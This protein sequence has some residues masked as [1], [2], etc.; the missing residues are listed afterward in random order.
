ML[1]DVIVVGSGI[2]GLSAALNAKKEGLKVAV[3][4]KSSLLR[5]NSAVASGGINAA[6]YS[7]E[8][9]SPELHAQDTIKAAEKLAKENTVKK[10]CEEAPNIINELISLG[11][12]FNKTDD[13]KIAQRAFGGGSKKR[14]CYV[15]DR[16]GSAIVMALLQACR[17]EE[18]DFFTNHYLLN[19]IT[20]KNQ[21]C[22]I[23]LLR[24]A[25]SRVT[26]LGCKALVLAGG[27][28]AGIFK[29]FTTNS[30]ESSGDLIAA[31]FRAGIKI[32]NMEFVQFHPTALKGSGSLISEAARGEGAYLVD[33]NNERF[34]SELATRDILT[35]D[36]L[37][38]IQN[39]HK[40]YL[41]FRH[42]PVEMIENRL[43]STYKTALM[44]AG[45]D[46]KKELLEIS[47]AA[48]YTIGGIWIRDDASTTMDGVYACGECAM[49]G[50]H[51]AN[52][53]GG[54]SLLESSYFGRIA[55]KEATTYAKK[56]KFKPV[57]FIQI[58]K[59]EQ[60]I[61]R[62]L[63]GES[64]YNV[65]SLKTN[66]GK[67]LFINAG[68]FRSEKS[69]LKAY[70]YISYLRGLKLGICCINKNRENNVE[71]PL[72]LEF[73]NS[74]LIAEVMVHSALYREESRGCLLYTSL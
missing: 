20:H 25:D 9:D 68:P 34:T 70:D 18:V 15:A 31:A 44:G 33:E 73:L 4:T 36:I 67:N 21:I 51:G 23:S 65:N 61:E 62:I 46:I 49:S 57:D 11:V 28:Y 35:R 17:K 69:L 63:K 53:L 39:G 12:K 64:L 38:H 29:G 45:V 7:D 26:A 54:N 27:G 2:A 8:G 40:V 16:T 10:M 56:E 47:P 58:E 41:D 3:V 43:P 42:L 71:L 66:L 59:D 19:L 52:R 24:K 60:E 5:S 14:T 6:L 72:I 55:G 37:K 74:L 13:N 1:Y 22:G 30:Q 32:S 48:H 50:V